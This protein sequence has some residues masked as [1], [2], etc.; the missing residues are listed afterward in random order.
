MENQFDIHKIANLCF[1]LINNSNYDAKASE[2]YYNKVNYKKVEIEENSIKNN[3]MGSHYGI[4]IRVINKSGSLGFAYT[5]NLKDISI[6]KMVNNALKLMNSGTSDPDFL[7][8]PNEPKDYPKVNG[9]FDK[10]IHNLQLEEF[11]DHANQL[12]DLCKK[13]KKAISQSAKLSSIS[14]KTLIMNSN[15]IDAEIEET[16][17]S[18]NSN[19][20]VKDRISGERSFGYDWQAVR[21]F[22]ELDSFEVGKNALDDALTNLHRKKIESKSLPI[23]LSPKAT[24][25][26]IL[27]PIRLRPIEY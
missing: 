9:L 21:Y 7:N 24:I 14:S 6:N 15:G 23:I 4:S 16:S 22:S 10:E 1:N 13:E 12:I 2:I 18:V 11:L 26:F 17:C 8:L 19:M 3:E 5:N 27:D 25:N 20:I